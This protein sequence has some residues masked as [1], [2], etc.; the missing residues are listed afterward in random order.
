MRCP[1][2]ESGAETL[3]AMQGSVRYLRRLIPEN[4]E[5]VESVTAEGNL[6][7]MPPANNWRKRTSGG[8]W[9]AAGGKTSA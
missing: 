4:L 8:A 1:D 5:S 7:A 9:S 3:I 2:P 6:V